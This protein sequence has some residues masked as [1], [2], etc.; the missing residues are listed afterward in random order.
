MHRIIIVFFVLG[1]GSCN[2]PIAVEQISLDKVES[3]DTLYF[4]EDMR[5]VSGVRLNFDTLTKDKF[6]P[7]NVW[8]NVYA[9]GKGTMN[10]ILKSSELFLQSE[11]SSFKI[12][13][14]SSDE[15]KFFIDNEYSGNAYEGSDPEAINL[16]EVDAYIQP[17]EGFVFKT[18]WRKEAYTAK[19]KTRVSR[20]SRYLEE[21]K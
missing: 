5:G 19:E 13:R 12:V 15:Y 3:I 10:D 1:L 2:E 14:V 7:R 9:E 17:H 11:D 20:L 4:T 21:V 6:V 18:Y 16:L 8:I